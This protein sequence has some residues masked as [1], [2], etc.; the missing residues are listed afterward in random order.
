MANSL[1]FSLFSILFAANAEGILGSRI[2]KKRSD[3]WIT[4]ASGASESGIR[5]SN[6]GL[7][8]EEFRRWMG[9][10][11]DNTVAQGGYA[12][13][14]GNGWCGCSCGHNQGNTTPCYTPPMQ[15][16]TA[17]GH[18]CGYFGVLYGC[19]EAHNTLE[20]CPR[21]RDQ[22]TTT[23]TASSSTTSGTQAAVSDEPTGWRVRAHDGNIVGGND[24]CWNIPFLVFYNEAG[25]HLE[26]DGP[27]G[28]QIVV[29]EDVSQVKTGMFTPAGKDGSYGLSLNGINGEKFLGLSCTMPVDITKVHISRSCWGTQAYY[30]AS[31]FDVQALKGGTWI[32][33][34]E[35]SFIEQGECGLQVV[36]TGLQA[37]VVVVRDVGDS[38][39]TGFQ[40]MSQERC[41]SG[42]TIEGIAYSHII[43]KCHSA[44]PDGCFQ[45]GTGIYYNT[46][47]GQGTTI[48]GHYGVCM[49]AI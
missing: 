45:H 2:N 22:T 5:A 46:C 16:G 7:S 43:S 42:A 49:K 13:G 17:G 11:Q 27:E 4:R 25:Q 26:V 8:T 15:P 29:S 34:K 48:V 40:P 24:C 36:E 23:T 30:M 19:A 44:W 33:V 41:E 3:N 47:Q 18:T 38:C 14:Y 6:I 10:L 28:C 21:T 9:L 35:H 32:T 37:D 39:P 12:C 31:E 1:G 20:G